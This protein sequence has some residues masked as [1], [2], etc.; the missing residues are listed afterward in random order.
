[1]VQVYVPN[2]ADAINA[3]EAGQQGAMERRKRQAAADI[4]GAM[5]RGDYAAAAQAAYGAGDYG[6]GS[7]ISKLGREF[8]AE[9][10][11]KGYGEKVASGDFKGAQNDALA[12][13]DLDYYA[14]L[15]KI[16]DDK[17]LEKAKAFGGILRAV[18]QE[19]EDRWDDLIQANRAQLEA[20]DIPASEI[21]FFVNAAPD[22]RRVLMATMLSRADMLDGY[23]K[24]REA[25]R[26]PDWREIKNPDGSTTFV[27]FNDA[28]A[29]RQ[30]GQTAQAA[31]SNMDA[32]FG[33]LIQQE[34]GGRPGVSGPQT[35]YGVAQGMTQMLPATAQSMAEKLGVAWRPDLMTGT[36]AE[37][38]N[39]QRQLGRAYFDEGLQR[40]GGDV[41][42]A[43]AY[44][45]GGPDESIW[46]PKT[47]QYVDSV[48]GRVSNQVAAAPG[49]DVLAGGSGSDQVQPYEVASVGQ[50]PPPPTAGGLRTRQGS[51]APRP[52]WEDQPDGTQRNI[53]T[54]ERKGDRSGAAG[55]TPKQLNEATL[56]IKSKFEALPQIKAFRDVQASFGVINSIAKKADPTAADDLA[57]IFSF[58]KMLD[59]GSVV[60]EGE[61]ANAQNSAGVPDQI[62]NAY[63]RVKSGERLNPSQRTQFAQSAG[64]VVIDRRRVFDQTAIEYRRLAS[65]TG[66]NPD[67]IAPVPGAW[68]KR[69]AERDKAAGKLTTEQ[70]KAA[71][72]E[73]R[74][75]IRRG[76]DRAKVIER[77]RKAGVST[78]G[79]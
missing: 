49:T 37:A 40:Y 1:M 2:V 13:G 29:S 74:D 56:D 39:Y 18:G 42:K 61:F 35:Q 50:T 65:D 58:M 43:L 62:R 47:R 36:S 70:S 17:K 12:G 72:A 44:Y 38:A 3:F 10:R 8:Q 73:A 28:N 64:Q 21:D 54:G 46:G 71:L 27:D 76:A 31:P 63:N 7:Q 5:A 26:K 30:V 4:S 32:V 67:R 9:A 33:A 34:S 48:L 14:A 51:A 24:D 19:P 53:R 16:A 69:A 45:H 22:Q 60:R 52:E 41:R 78:Q 59:P 25:A 57:L 55:Y 15:G 20:L 68:E 75:A 79:L 23:L 6:V 11:R 66:V 77:L